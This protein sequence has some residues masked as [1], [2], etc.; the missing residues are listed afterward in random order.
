MYVK[1]AAMPNVPLMNVTVG[2]APEV[3]VESV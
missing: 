1:F 3:R 2:A